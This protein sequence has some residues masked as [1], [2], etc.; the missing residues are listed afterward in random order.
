[1]DYRQFLYERLREGK[2]GDL[3]QTAGEFLEGFKETELSKIEN[4]FSLEDLD[5][6][7]T[8]IICDFF[9]HPLSSLEGYTKTEEYFKRQILTLIIRKINKRN[10]ESYKKTGWIYYLNAMA[11][12]TYKAGLGD[13]FLVFNEFWES[14]ENSDFSNSAFMFDSHLPNILYV[15]E[16]QK[17]SIIDDEYPIGVLPDNYKT[18]DGLFS[19]DP[20]NP[21]MDAGG[22]N[23]KYYKLTG[24]VEVLDN[25]F[26]YLPNNSPFTFDGDLGFDG[27]VINNSLSRIVLFHFTQNYC[28]NDEEFLSRNSSIALEGDLRQIKDLTSSICFEPCL[29]LNLDSSGDENIEKY[30]T[31]NNLKEKTAVIKSKM[32]KH[33]NNP[34]DYVE[35]IKFGDGRLED[36]NGATN[37][38]SSLI[39]Y[40]VDDYVIEKKDYNYC[41]I[42]KKIVPTDDVFD[43]SEVGFFD[44]YGDLIFY[45]CF[46]FVR[47]K[48][49]A[50]KNW[51]L[52]INTF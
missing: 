41:H 13:Y 5:F 1:M 6:G 38:K 42:R 47:Y 27:E 43:Y 34:F 16:G 51:C 39:S 49:K 12:P 45:A 19:D 50:Y 40:G 22:G 46:P 23:I 7:K 30:G 8:K 18:D 26:P 52:K 32:Y 21:I 20:L 35:T 14:D 3:V 44:M 28:E 24:F 29:M 10:L 4:L 33:F 9:G 11:Y 36:L 2:W 31:F 15:L 37:L 48:V 17:E 25:N